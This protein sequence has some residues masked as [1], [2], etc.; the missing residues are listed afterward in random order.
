VVGDQG[1]WPIFGSDDDW[2][3]GLDC[4]LPRLPPEGQGLPA[5]IGLARG[6]GVAAVGDDLA[7]REVE[8]PDIGHVLRRVG[9]RLLGETVSQRR[10]AGASQ[11]AHVAGIV[12]RLARDVD[13]HTG[14]RVQ[15]R[16]RDQLLHL[17]IGCPLGEDADLYPHGR[18]LADSP[19]T[20]S[21]GRSGARPI[22]DRA[23]CQEDRLMTEVRIR[24]RRWPVRGWSR[25]ADGRVRGE[26]FTA[27]CLPRR[28]ELP[29]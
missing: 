28:H 17:G 20:D 7:V 6:V 19:R 15:A 22:L 16:V 1:T 12:L 3:T 18:R 24:P 5:E 21:T 27:A 26:S 4:P 8:L 13:L 9:A 29:G 2:L 14:G 10:T 25:S 23:G 11:G